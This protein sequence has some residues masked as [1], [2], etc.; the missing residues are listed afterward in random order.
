M[1]MNPEP[2]CVRIKREAQESIARA[3]EGMTPR[4]RDAYINKQAEALAK[5][6]GFDRVSRPIGRGPEVGS[7]GDRKAG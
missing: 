6:L 1:T 2:E 7:A 4:E 5:K 3:T